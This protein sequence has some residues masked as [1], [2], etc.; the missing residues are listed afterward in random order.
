MVGNE[1]TYIA[2]AVKRGGT[3]GN[4]YYTKCCHRFFEERYGFKKVLLTSSCTDALEMAAILL[5]IKAGDEVIV[6]SYTFV[7][8]ANAFVL[9]GA[10]IVFADSNKS[11]PN[12]DTELLR[13][14]ITPRTKA[15]VVVHYAGMACDMDAIM[16]LAKEFNLYV[17]EDAA[18]AIDAYFTDRPLGGIGHLGCFSFH[19]SKNI[20]CGEGGML[21]INDEKFI[22]RAEI[23]WEKGTNRASFCRGELGEYNWVDIGSS[24]LLSDIQ[25][26]FLYGQL[27]KLDEVQT[28]RYQIWQHYRQNLILPENV[29]PSIPVYAAHNAHLFYLVCASQHERDALSAFLNQKGIEA[30]T[31]YLPLHKSPFYKHQH[32]GRL[33][34]NALHYT[35][36][37]LRI[38]LC[39]A[40]DTVQQNYIINKINEFY[41]ELPNKFEAPKKRIA[42]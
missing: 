12:M 17:V 8:S 19:E 7:S 31:H 2:D 4:G 25:A 10:S 3:A 6:P 22:E 26:A 40:L 24:F 14:L 34:S 11:N 16:S 21:V 20:S 42:I 15:I 41:H 32:D 23:I 28:R 35:K 36:T 37:L 9:R 13:A 39:Y 5:N 27:E 33:L 38:P 29:F 1:L 30:L 18:Q